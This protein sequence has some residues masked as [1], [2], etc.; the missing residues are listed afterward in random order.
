M[1]SLDNLYKPILAPNE[2]PEA[3][4]RTRQIAWRKAWSDEGVDPGKGAAPAQDDED[5]QQDQGGDDRD[6]SPLLVVDEK[7]PELAE[8]ARRSFLGHRLEFRASLLV[9][10]RWIHV[11]SPR[12]EDGA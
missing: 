8:K 1:A 2:P 10:F 11:S 6:E 5:R 7:V 4:A 3:I 12:L 9:R